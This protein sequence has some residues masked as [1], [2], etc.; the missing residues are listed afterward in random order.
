MREI[1]AQ[2]GTI[3]NRVFVTAWRASK[4]RRHSLARLEMPATRNAY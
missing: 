2:A 1:A 4:C 3:V